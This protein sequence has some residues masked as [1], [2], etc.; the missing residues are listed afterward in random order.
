MPGDTGIAAIV[1]T[2]SKSSSDLFVSLY[3]FLTTSGS[4]VAGISLVAN[5][6][7]SAPNGGFNYWDQ[8]TPIGNDAWAVF[9]FTSSSIPFYMLLQ[10]ATSSTAIFPFGSTIGGR[11]ALLSNQ[12]AQYRDRGGVGIQFAMRADGLSPWAGAS[13]ALGNDLKGNPVWTTGSHGLDPQCAF[14]WPRANSV[15]GSAAVSLTSGSRERCLNISPQVWSDGTLATGVRVHFACDFN[16]VAIAKDTFNNVGSYNY[17]WFGKYQPATGSWPVGSASLNVPVPYAMLW[18]D[19]ETTLDP[20][21]AL[22]SVH[23]SLT[24]DGGNE[25]GIA[26]PILSGQVVNVVPG[27]LSVIPV[28]STF[29][30]NTLYSNPRA[31]DEFPLMLYMFETGGG[32]LRDSFGYLGE[33]DYL[34]LNYALLV[35]DLASGSVNGITSGSTIG[36]LRIVLGSQPTVPNVSKFSFPWSPNVPDTFLSGGSGVGS[37]TGSYF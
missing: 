32:E 27:T 24:G 18:R 33:T 20:T 37:R 28:N 17:L 35:G 10:Y 31:Y 5:N 36:Q 25:G 23:G 14:V 12:S 1:A 21:I 9:C 13:G 4:T 11:P 3:K 16:N 30:P 34:R 2:G 8:A 15:S 19:A 29:H 22:G 6:S 7:G 26:H